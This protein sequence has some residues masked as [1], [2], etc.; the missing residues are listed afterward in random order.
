M[1]LGCPFGG[2]AI[3]YRRTLSPFVS[4]VCSLSKRFC[5]ISL[6]LCDPTSNSI[7]NTLLINVYLPT[8]YN[9][10][11]SNNAF[12]ESIAELDGFISAQSFDN[13]IICGD[14]NVDFSHNNNNCV[15]LSDPMCTYDLIRAASNSSISYTYRRDDMS[16]HSWPDHV[17]LKYFMHIV[18]EV[19]C[20]DSV[21]NFSDHLP[22]YLSQLLQHLLITSPMIA[23]PLK[24]S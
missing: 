1:L 8:N 20:E 16:A 22:L 2:C 13:L 17:L 11:D 24:A 7:I 12:L 21:D 4:R 10:D 23:V 14:F 15:V 18:K 19:A 6:R 5:T 3:L 9:T